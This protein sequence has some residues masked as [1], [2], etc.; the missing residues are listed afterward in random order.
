MNSR[1]VPWIIAGA[2]VAA[3]GIV[4]AFGPLNP[5][6]GTV[7]P[8]YKTLTDVEPRTAISA[9][10]TPGDA[11]SLY[12]ITQPGSYYLTGNITGT[13][14]KHGI[15]IASSGVTLDLGGF[16]LVG[17]GPASGA[18]DGIS[19]TV[20]SLTN[21]T[22]KNGSV[23]NWGDGGVDLGFLANGARVEKVAA[24]GNGGIGISGAI[25]CVIT[26]CT[27]F[28]NGAVT[29]PPVGGLAGI[30]AS[31]GSTISNCSASSNSG[32][33]IYVN[34]GCSI[35]GCSTYFNGAGAGTAVNVAGISTGSACT[36]TASSA[37]TNHAHG[38]YL[39]DS[40]SAR[41]CTTQ[42]NAR[43]GIFANPGA[44]LAQCTSSFNTGHGIQ[45]GDTSTAA[46]CTVRN[47]QGCGIFAGRE[48][49]ADACT[50][51]AN[52]SHG[53]QFA[54]SGTAS[55]CTARGNGG[56]GLLGGA[57]FHAERCTATFNTSH[58][59]DLGN[60]GSAALGCS[61]H[62]N[63]GCGIKTQQGGLVADCTV[64]YNDSD[65]IQASSLS[66]IRGNSCFANQ[67]SDGAGAGISTSGSFTRIEG[68]SCTANNRGIET[69]SDRNII[70]RNTCGFNTTNWVMAAGN[71]I[72]V[73]VPGGSA[74]FTTNGNGG[75]GYNTTDP[76]ANFS[77]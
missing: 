56:C 53:M 34:H 13:A 24:S 11:D 3:S 4:T 54:E 1:A 67:S 46:G 47:N 12:K 28:S 37:Y 33:G 26:D 52:A 55:G 32:P 62:Q 43:V 45:L 64:S 72:L 73:V 41:D 29:P 31:N 49:A 25:A 76:N 15:E 44:T 22:V 8:T 35:S 48:C 57:S 60:D 50:A 70:L 39:G 40:S 10:G 20:N 58:G 59:I 51:S 23:R 6:A 36:V 19:V 77:Y 68:N 18:F 71:K 63:S 66:T 74:A 38:I 17:Q 14:G 61:A 9:A 65:G 69:D 2:A 27:A 7:A 16:D 30:R 5:P 42:S 21:I 75:S